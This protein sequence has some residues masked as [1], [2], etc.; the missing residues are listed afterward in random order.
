MEKRSK[1]VKK[2][3]VGRVLSWLA[4]LSFGTPVVLL[5]VILVALSIFFRTDFFQIR[6]RDA[7]VHS[8][9]KSL[10]LKITYSEAQV[11]V[12]SLYPTI[13]F[14]GLKLHHDATKTDVEIGKVTVAISMFWSIPLLF[15]NKI[16][17]SRAE[18]EDLSYKLTD[19]KVI[20][21]WL[22]KLKPEKTNIPLDFETLIGI[23]R[24][25]NFNLE[26]DLARGQLGPDAIRARANLESFD[27]QFDTEALTMDG[28]LHLESVAYK[29]YEFQKLDLEL[30]EAELLGERLRI[31]KF[32]LVRDE[33]FVAISGEIKRWSDPIIDLSIRSELE[34]EKHFSYEDLHGHLSLQSDFRGPLKRLEGAGKLTLVGAGFRSKNIDELSMSWKQSVGEFAVQDIVVKDDD[35]IIQGQASFDFFNNAQ[36]D[37][38]LKLAN[39]PLGSYLGIVEED[40]GYW[41]GKIN[42]DL[43]I[44]G[45]LNSDQPLKVSADLAV[46]GFK[47]T[48]GKSETLV[49]GIDQARAKIQLDLARSGANFTAEVKTPNSDWE[50]M[51]EW[52]AEKFGLRW[53]SEIRGEVGDLFWFRLAGRGRLPGSY[54]GPLDHIVLS[55]NPD[56]KQFSLN[57]HIFENIKGELRLE[58]RRLYANPI[59]ANGL[60]LQGGLYFEPGRKGRTLFSDFD[61]SFSQQ[62]SLTAL[63]SLPQTNSWVIKPE[64]YA[65]G[66]GRLT[67]WVGRPKGSGNILA[68]NLRIGKDP[69]SGRRAKANWVFDS[70]V[71][72]F[73]DVYIETSR[74][75]GGVLG[76]MSFLISGIRDFHL[77]G[78][79]VRLADWLSVFDANAPFQSLLNFNLNYDISDDS[80]S[81]N[82]DFFETMI[83]SRIQRPSTVNIQ[84]ISESTR[85]LAE[86]FEGEISVELRSKAAGLAGVA[87]NINDW[88]IASLVRE[89]FENGVK[90]LLNGSGSCNLEFDSLVMKRQSFVRFLAPPKSLTCT[91]QIERSDVTRGKLILHSIDPFQ[92]EL[93]KLGSE[94][95]I[96]RTD[97]LRVLSGEEELIV[98]G[99]FQSFRKLNVSVEGRTRLESVSYFVPFLSRSEGEFETHGKWTERG[100]TGVMTLDSGLMLLQSSPILVRNVTARLRAQDSLFDVGQL[101]GEIRDGSLTASG[102][103]QLKGLDI[104]FAYLNLQMNGPLFEP[105]PD[106]R[107]RAT[108]PLN[109]KVENNDAVLS[110]QLNVYEGIYRKRIN[111][112]T[113]ILSIFEK[114]PDKYKFFAE[115]ES[116]FD[117]W[118]LDVGLK[119]SE[120]FAIR[121]NLAEGTVDLDVRVKG[122]IK[123]PILDGR[124]GLIR[125][126]FNYIKQTFEL[127][128]G[129]LQFSENQPNIP[130][131]D[132]RAETQIDDYRVFITLQGDDKDQKVFYSSDP[133][134]NEK[135][136]L[137]LVSYGTPPV[138]DDQTAQDDS[139]KSAAYTGISF[140]TGS[141]QD[142]IEGTLATDLGIRRFQLYP[143]FY[144]ETG[145]TEL[146]LT[147]GTDLIKNRLQ[148]NYSNFLSVS[149]G[150]Q[151]ELD[152]KVARNV[153][154]IGSWRDTNQA[155]N[156]TLSGDLGGD[157]IFHFEF[158]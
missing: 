115:E 147:V 137:A 96:W 34:I 87:I 127:Q 35:E 68:E 59:T 80:M 10:E 121:N 42:G 153:S 104:S 18:V 66:S 17:I 124:I 157:L 95:A 81:A 78:K 74:E 99:S 138:L 72:Y 97:R 134:L 37:M 11:R 49:Y 148:L 53:D 158:D 52:D 6:L 83:G 131:Y 54:S 47:V 76:G 31:K 119:T 106:I 82:F 145:R 69:T 89:L 135:Q 113:D 94:E 24:F 12:L 41:G 101:T 4:G 136:I 29:G 46:D 8:A 60:K 125:G 151:I 20:N 139:T 132:I 114:K 110:G 92:L 77:T 141:L 100:F 62:N 133:P 117:R 103:F 67:D 36:L 7:V 22:K 150:H 85:V 155:S 116:F 51:G 156:T 56:L 2:W 154:L 58:S 23:I 19:I 63:N 79:K 91:S 122:T 128:S 13:N 90:L 93:E 120:P 86:I 27:I 1:K 61:F 102:R 149:G 88:A 3:S 107:F 38:R 118:R 45:Q 144:D 75:G 26:L 39:S 140:V 40:L 32:N 109:L 71:L 142:T 14:L 143:S 105:E 84:T 70:G 25:K 65:S 129:S 15:F 130:R 33:D 28:R 108:G 44:I 152:L 48:Q 55:V 98:S 16:Y 146:Q 50:A 64:S 43:S 5:L 112:R 123:E 73:N 9:E 30:R 21:R 57:E 126:H 111:I